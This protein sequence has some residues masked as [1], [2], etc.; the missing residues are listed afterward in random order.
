M[1]MLQTPE[2]SREMER[3]LLQRL[4]S[5]AARFPRTAAIASLLD[6][7]LDAVVLATGA[8]CGN[9]Q[10]VNPATGALEI[11]AQRGFSRE[12]LDFFATVHLD[13]SACASALRDRR[14]VIVT[15]VAA[16]AN[17]SEDS[18]EVVLRAGVRAVQ[19]T[20]ML[21][22]AGAVVGMLSSHHGKPTEVPARALALVGL[23]ARRAG[24]L[25]ELRA[26]SRDGPGGAL[27]PD[28]IIRLKLAAGLLPPVTSTRT[29]A[30]PGQGGPCSACELAISRAQ[31]EY[32]LDSGGRAYR[33]HLG[34]FWLWERTRYLPAGPVSGRRP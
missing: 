9:V 23:F 12:F 10:L 14:P 18:R 1:A 20:P 13:G 21:T 30:G 15:D 24:A 4:D 34:C 29:W 25:I 2:L 3:E 8:E 6:D 27:R 26:A 16:D 11:A 19:S 7:T 22:I 33:F 31:T 32:E 28:A 5:M 17:F